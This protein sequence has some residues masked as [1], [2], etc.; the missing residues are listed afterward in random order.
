LIAGH[1][2]ARTVCVDGLLAVR[3]CGHPVTVI[4]S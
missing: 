4:S 1:A 2:C 3:V